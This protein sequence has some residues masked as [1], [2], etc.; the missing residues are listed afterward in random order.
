MYLE[1]LVEYIHIRNGISP[2][3][4]Q[5]LWSSWVSFVL[6]ELNE[7]AAA[8]TDKH[9]NEELGDVLIIVLSLC[10]R[11]G[12]LPDIFEAAYNKMRRRAPYVADGLVP[13]MEQELKMWR[14]GR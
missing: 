11:Y 7:V 6:D 5:Q 13:T 9:R 10:S 3:C 8:K 12:S 2:W 1:K 4:K 14:D